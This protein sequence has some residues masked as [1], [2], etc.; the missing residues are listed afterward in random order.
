M[1]CIAWAQ[2]IVGDNPG[3]EVTA[4][5]LQQE[6]L[7]EEELKNIHSVSLA[8]ES[9]KGSTQQPGCSRERENRDST[10]DMSSESNTEESGTLDKLRWELYNTNNND[11]RRW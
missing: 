8:E 4:P 5:A 9:I 3:S 6:G 1:D 10:M 2:Y 11:M 7:S